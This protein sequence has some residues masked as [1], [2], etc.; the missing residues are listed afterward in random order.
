MEGTTVESIFG[1]EELKVVLTIKLGEPLNDVR[2]VHKQPHDVYLR[3]TEGF[4]V[5]FAK[6]DSVVGSQQEFGWTTKDIYLKSGSN[7]KQREFTKLTA[8]EFDAHVVKSWRNA[9]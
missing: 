9:Q 1:E 8:E 7:T 2:A 4:A 3:P 5:L 6:A